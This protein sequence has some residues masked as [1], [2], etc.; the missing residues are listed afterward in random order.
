MTI[1]PFLPEECTG[2]ANTRE[3]K[4]GNMNIE[5]KKWSFDATCMD[6]F[7]AGKPKSKLPFFNRNLFLI[8]IAMF[9]NQIKVSTF[10]QGTLQVNG[11]E[12]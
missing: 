5:I 1:V 2:G 3:K 9:D 7:L 10:L 12:L 4:S 8:N 11:K 6:T